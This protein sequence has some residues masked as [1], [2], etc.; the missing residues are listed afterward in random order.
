MQPMDLS[1]VLCKVQTSF[2]TFFLAKNFSAEMVANIHGFLQVDDREY[3]H[4]SDFLKDIDLIVDNAKSY[5]PAGDPI[6][7]RV[8][9]LFT[10]F[11][12]ILGITF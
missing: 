2:D 7:H 11:V 5:N 10:K 9:L 1:T 3:T 6:I 8:I 12:Y 4:P